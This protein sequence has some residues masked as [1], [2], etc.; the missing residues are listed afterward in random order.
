MSGTGE[1]KKLEN[2]IFSI[3]LCCWDQNTVVSDFK[4]R[5]TAR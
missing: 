1:G 2:W 5:E 3:R 4:G